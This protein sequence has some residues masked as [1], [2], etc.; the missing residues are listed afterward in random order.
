M[1]PAP[2]PKARQKVAV[3]EPAMWLKLDFQQERSVLANL[4]ALKMQS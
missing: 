3:V 4:V 2:G 1:N